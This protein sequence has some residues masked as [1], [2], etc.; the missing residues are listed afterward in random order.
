MKIFAYF[1][2]FFCFASLG[3]VACTQGPASILHKT[4]SSVEQR[5]S[6]SD[7]CTIASY[8]E[9]PQVMVSETT[10]GYSSPATTTCN[11]TDGNT[12]CE[13]VDGL[14]VGPSITTFDENRDL[15]QRYVDRCLISKGYQRIVKPICKTTAESAAARVA[16]QNQPPADQIQCVRR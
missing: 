2:A 4:G 14:D 3:L 13:T 9:I 5:I 1:T 6:A 11:T 7:Q 10:P 12:T 16:E 15:R 8:R